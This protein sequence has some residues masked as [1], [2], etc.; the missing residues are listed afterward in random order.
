MLLCSNIH[1]CIVG[2]GY[3]S[4]LVYACVVS[5]AL[6]FLARSLCVSSSYVSVMY[7][8]AVMFQSCIVQQYNSLS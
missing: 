7:C 8:P 1:N 4:D 3:Y 2:S 5:D 6:T